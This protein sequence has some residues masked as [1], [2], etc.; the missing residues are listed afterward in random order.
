MVDLMASRRRIGIVLALLCGLTEAGLA[1][2]RGP[3]VR[4]NLSFAAGA[5]PARQTDGAGLRAACHELRRGPANAEAHRDLRQYDKRR[6]AAIS[7]GR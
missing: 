6:T 2:E 5:F 3:R 7:C 1:R 4:G